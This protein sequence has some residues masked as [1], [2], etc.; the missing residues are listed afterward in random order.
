M[1]IALDSDLSIRAEEVL[2]LVTDT[3]GNV[4]VVASH[5]RYTI[6]CDSGDEARRR[7]EELT[8]IINRHAFS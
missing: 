5:G 3:R 1:L 4:I 7:I 2:A 6:Y 8:D